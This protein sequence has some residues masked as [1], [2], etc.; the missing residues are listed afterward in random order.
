[1]RKVY[2]FLSITIM[3]L[4]FMLPILM[5]PFVKVLPVLQLNNMWHRSPVYIGLLL[6]TF[7]LGYLGAKIENRRLMIK[8]LT[9]N[10]KSNVIGALAF[11]L[12]G[13]MTTAN[14]I[15]ILVKALPNEPYK[16]QVEVI[17]VEPQGSKQQSLTLK[18]DQL[19]VLFNLEMADVLFH[20][21]NQP[22]LQ[23]GDTLL[24]NGKENSF[25]VYIEKIIIYPKGN[26]I[27]PFVLNISLG[28]RIFILPILF[29]CGLTAFCYFVVV[30]PLSKNHN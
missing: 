25:G 4:G 8:T 26:K 23:V 1:M 21:R 14:T 5:L 18:D 10:K 19:S 11:V 30:K 6:G 9:E 12:G 28:N 27:N 29:V 22:D 17:S 13:A 15:G 7:A 16:K 20:Y 3:L 24:L 2:L